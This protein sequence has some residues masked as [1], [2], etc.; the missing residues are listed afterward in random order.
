M[1]GNQ[2]KVNKKRT[3]VAYSHPDSMISE[4]YRM[5]EANIKFS[6]ADQKSR[7]FLITSPST[8]EGKST[9]ASNLAATMAQKQKKVLLIDANFRSPILHSIFKISNSSG[10][11]DVLI[12]QSTFD[13]AVCHTDIENLDILASGYAPINHGK[14]LDSYKMQEILNKAY[15]SYD[16]VIIDSHSILELTETKILASQCDGVVLVIKKGKTLLEKAA[17]SKKVLEFAKA[18]LVGVILNE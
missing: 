17:E 12:D 5:I 2:K 6:M 18:K 13:E 8:G 3:L 1:N 4:Q 11:A 7:S 9:S 16:V 14:L 15:Q 10:L